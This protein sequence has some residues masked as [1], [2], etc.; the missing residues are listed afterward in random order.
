MLIVIIY[1]TMQSD[2]ILFHV[3]GNA[4]RLNIPEH[5]DSTLVKRLDVVKRQL[6][7]RATLDA[8]EVMLVEDADPFRET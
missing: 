8:G 6:L 7:G 2:I 1:L 5:I 4:K 3:A